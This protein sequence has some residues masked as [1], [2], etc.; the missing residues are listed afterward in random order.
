MYGMTASGLT[1]TAATYARDLLE[2]VITSFLGGFLA[3]LVVTRPLDGS[4]WWT[5][6]AGG[7]AAAVSLLKGILA[8]LTGDANSASLSGR[9]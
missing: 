9:V 2:R 3:G 1:R 6:A 4:M 8:R 5:A 7:V